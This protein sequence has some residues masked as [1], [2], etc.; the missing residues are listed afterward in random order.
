MSFFKNRAGLGGDGSN[1]SSP[2]PRQGSPAATSS[3]KLEAPVIAPV[4]VSQDYG[5][6]SA[7]GSGFGLKMLEKMGWK[8]GYGLGVGGTGIVEPIQTKLRPVK[9]GIGFKGFKEKTD[10]TRA[11]EKRRGVEVSSD[12]DEEPAKLRSKAGAKK[13]Q[14]IK[15][16]GWKKSSSRGPRKAKVEYKTA[17]EIQRE[18]ESGDLP[19]TQVQPQK[20]LDMTGKTVRE[21]SSA[22]LITSTTPFEHE[23]FPELRHNLQLMADISTTD[24]EQL[25][26][27][28]KADHVRQKVLE[29]EGERMQKLISQDEINLERLTRVL[30][31]TDQCSKIANE[32]HEATSDTS[33]RVAVDIKEDYIAN[34]FKEPFDMFSGLYFEEY[35]L[36]ELDQAFFAALQDSFKRLLKDWNVLGN[37]T[38]GAGLFRRW[39]KLLRKS[40]VVYNNDRNTE[41]FYGSKPVQPEQMTAYE[42]L[43]N[44]HWLPK[45][46]SAINNEWN[47]RDCDPVIELLEAWAPP[48][49]PEFIYDNIITQLI[50]PK[51]QKEVDI[52]NPRDSLMLHTWIHPW[53]PV[54][55]QPLMDQELFDTVRRK[56]ASGLKA[57]NVLDPSALHIL[58]PW[59]GVFEDSDMEVLLLKSVLP[60][61]VEGLAL[62][63]I[64]PRNQKIEI[65]QAI[66]PWHSYFP[67][68]TFSSLLVNEFFPKWHQ[69]LY[70]WLTH[71]STT[72]LE[73]VS[74]WYQW[75]KSLFPAEL[76]QE[77][78]VALGFRQGLDMINQFMAGLQIMAPADLAQAQAQTQQKQQ[79]GKAGSSGSSASAEALGRLQTKKHLVT[80][81]SF[82]D[83]VQDYATQNSLLFVMTKQMHERSGK[84]LYRLGGNSTGTA[85]GILVHMTDEVAFVKSEET[86]VWTPTGLEE[87]MLLAG[88]GKTKGTAGGGEQRSR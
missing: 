57:W 3:P 2:S 25:A 22:S 31:I 47:A 74:Q 7:K 8:K 85:G 39:H 19:M 55:G 13:E 71:P 21:L 61:L 53:L 5:A 81:M 72:D 41:S 38:L 27:A 12:E 15:A 56:L 48:I 79:Q 9:M 51:L 50:L 6:F 82:K 83:L 20:I 73:Q 78:G 14:E 18:I 59:K 10:Q 67:S 65:L 86:G 54:L 76:V 45:V 40:K 1:S 11:E 49:L 17:E 44:Q 70:L 62:F 87:L 68:T 66:L 36:Y 69:V 42:S 88:A 24:L 77:T 75:W 52:W 34:A 35:Q 23:R 29:A 37:P 60:K 28:Q 16:D 63:E 84:P 33:G 43:L 80:T 46:R 4:K 64:N 30:A 32:I 58:G 26:R